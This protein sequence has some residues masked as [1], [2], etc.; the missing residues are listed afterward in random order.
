MMSSTDEI[1][2]TTSA[3]RGQTPPSAPQ[4]PHRYSLRRSLESGTLRAEPHGGAMLL[5]GHSLPLSEHYKG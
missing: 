4:S 2:A 1:Y 3:H 5:L